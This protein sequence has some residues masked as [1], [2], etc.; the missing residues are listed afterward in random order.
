LQHEIARDLALSDLNHALY[1]GR[2][3]GRAEAALKE[4]REFVQD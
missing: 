1:L 2:Q 3:L 4:G